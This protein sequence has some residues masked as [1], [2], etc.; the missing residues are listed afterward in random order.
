MR[1][2]IF[3]THCSAKKNDISVDESVTPDLL[4]S[5]AFIQRFI[6]R[7]ND[8]NNKWA[9]FSD[10]YGVW[11]PDVKH[12]MYDKHPGSVTNEEFKVL[13]DNFSINLVKY[14]EIIFYYNPGR[15]H[16]IYDKI[17]NETSLK[18]KVRR[19]THLSEID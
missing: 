10:L 14:D 7:C 9:I 17:L 19:I 3:L 12:P 11:F 8:K 5:A 2:R 18:N 1:N 15:F 16:P 13:L 4:Y 6:K